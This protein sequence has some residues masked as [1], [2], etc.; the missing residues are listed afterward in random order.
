MFKKIRNQL[1]ILFSILMILFLVSFII[2]SYF[3]LSFI[4]YNDSR[5][6]IQT[7][8]VS[9]LADHKAEL[10]HNVSKNES[11]SIEYK[12]NS[13]S[14]YFVINDQNQILSG[15]EI[16]PEIRADI[17]KRM[18]GWK[19]TAEEVRM[20]KFK[21]NGRGDV[22]FMIA[23]REVYNANRYLGVVY[24]GTDIT[25]Q[26]NVFQRIIWILIYVSVVFILLSTVL[27]YYMA[28][29]AMRPIMRSFLRQR[30]FVADASH[31]LRTPLS[32]LQSSLEVLKKEQES[33][34]DFS[35]QILDDMKEEVGRMTGLVRDLL[36][37]ARADSGSVELSCERFNIVTLTE[38]LVRSFQM[39]AR[40]RQQHLTLIVP[41][42]LHVYADKERIA[43]LIYIL[44]DNASKYTP[45]NG[46]ITLRID[47][48]EK[49]RGNKIRMIVQD[50][51]IGIAQD[52]QARIYDRF[53]RIDKGRSRELGGT[54]L[55]LSIASWI[56]NAHRGSIHL[57]SAP[58]QGSTFTVRLPIR[59]N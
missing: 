55:G 35:H 15:H 20:E 46:E 25:Q 27:G 41:N 7:L 59:E 58:G 51:G 39:L 16:M 8:A 32:V 10:M 24:T 5:N 9:E 22:Y 21:L 13:H 11:H 38:Q 34:S 47:E 28:G 1:T 49:G 56:I 45:A 4:L 2:I 30:E 26:R 3:L 54:G 29:K 19:P 31:E 36:T 18:E 17:L 50:T 52:E 43:Q 33:L 57:Q 23:G 6:D 37:L 44:L 48:E 14:F 42:E 12:E 53:Y 40:K